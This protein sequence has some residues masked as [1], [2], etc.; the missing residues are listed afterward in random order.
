VVEQ[1]AS[2]YSKRRFTFVNTTD[3]LGLFAPT[4]IFSHVKIEVRRKDIS[5]RERRKT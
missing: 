5:D 2:S 1:F 3:Y 4:D